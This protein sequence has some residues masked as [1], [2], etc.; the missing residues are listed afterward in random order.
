MQH[1]LNLMRHGTRSQCNSSKLTVTWSLVLSSNTRRAAAFCTLC[2]LRQTG[3]RWVTVVYIWHMTNARTRRIITSRSSC[4]HADRSR[5][6][7]ADDS[8]KS[9]P[10]ALRAVSWTAG[11]QDE[12][13]GCGQ[14]LTVECCTHQLA[15]NSL[16]CYRWATGQVCCRDHAS[17]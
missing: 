10:L 1:S 7:G 15:V 11:C 16:N 9:R 4:Q 5:E 13:W 12:D 3:Q 2:R 6:G 8:G 14:Q 17:V